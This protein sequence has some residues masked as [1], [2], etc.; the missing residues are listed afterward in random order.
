MKKFIAR[1]PVTVLGRDY[2]SGDTFAAD[3]AEVGGLVE[4]G[5]AEPLDGVAAE[6][7]SL[8][9]TDPAA[10]KAAILDAI[11]QLDAD[12]PDVWLR[13]GRP[14]AAALAEIAGW[15]VSA[16]ERNAAWAAISPS[17]SGRG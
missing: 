6:A 13:D 11:A 4:S 3:P 2:R 8:A 5:S 12:N 9:P 10:R 17:P 14:D 7:V 16:A 1:A 15:T